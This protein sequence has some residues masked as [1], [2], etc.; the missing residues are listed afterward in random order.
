MDGEVTPDT[1][2]DPGLFDVELNYLFE[3]DG[4]HRAYELDVPEVRTLMTR[5]MLWAARD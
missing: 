5:G 1:L 3:A 2:A 4:M